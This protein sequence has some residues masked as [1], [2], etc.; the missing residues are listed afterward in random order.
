[1]VDLIKLEGESKI[2][3]N[4]FTKSQWNEIERQYEN[5]IIQMVLEIMSQLG[6]EQGSNT[7]DFDWCAPVS[8]PGKG[9]H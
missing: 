2:G 4:K 5:P 7:N 1:M 9:L 8:S 3:F 6:N